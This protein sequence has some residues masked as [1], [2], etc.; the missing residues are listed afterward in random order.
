MK[1]IYYFSVKCEYRYEIQARN[2]ETAR[3]IL[4]E[5]GGLDIQGEPLFLDDAYKRA[6]LVGVCR[7]EPAVRKEGNSND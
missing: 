5:K 1:D 6:E 7:G 4:Q 2:E 3:K